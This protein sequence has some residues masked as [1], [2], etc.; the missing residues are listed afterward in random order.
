MEKILS[1]ALFVLPIFVGAQSIST[2]VIA[3]SG[4]HFENGSVQ[5]SWT[6]GEIVVD[7]YNS[8]GNI[9]TQGF[10]QP[11][12]LITSIEELSELDLTVNIFPN[13]AADFINIEFTGNKTDMIVELF[14]MRGKE[15][16]RLDLSAYQ[17]ETG[18]N[19]SNIGS[20]G[21]LLRLTEENGKYISTYQIQKGR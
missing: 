12:L 9:L 17:M 11:E 15:V 2:E 13:P 16:T 1:I 7:T 5:L 21:Y 10:H 19:V 14:D 3:S 18:I 4:E 8:G 6:L 20:G